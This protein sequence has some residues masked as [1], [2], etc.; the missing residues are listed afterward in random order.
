MLKPADRVEI[1]VLVDNYTDMFVPPTTPVDRRLPF[2][3]NRMLLA[4]HGLSCLVRIFAGNNEH[5]IL[6]DAGLSRNGL[7]HN[8]RELGIDLRTAEA[9]VLS[10]GHFDH[11][12]GLMDLFEGATHQLPVIAHPDAFLKR[13]L[14]IPGK[15]PVDLPQLDAV[16]LKKA[17]ADIQQ[18]TGPSTLAGGC[19]IVTGVVERKNSFE[20]GM[21]G[22]E[23]FIDERWQA[24]PINDDQALVINV[25]DKGLVVI[26]GCAHA[27]IINTVEYAKKCTGVDHIHAVLGGF[28]LSGQGFA[29]V[30]PPTV[31]AMKRINPDYIVPMHCTGW[32]AMTRFFEEMPG[33]CILNTVGTTFVF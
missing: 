8:A 23:A 2:S 28:H 5:T 19:L 13:R 30:I 15:S 4:E 32:E 7:F 1:T 25:K 27:G 33:K 31:D 9:V 11:F 3:T 24:D 14:N 12:G 20:K 22:M 6:L 21:P 17:G 29:Q 26:S 10:H 18:K 16:A